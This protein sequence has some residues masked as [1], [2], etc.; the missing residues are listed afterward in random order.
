[1]ITVDSLCLALGWE[2]TH[3]DAAGASWCT[4]SGWRAWR[5]YASE[6][7]ALLALPLERLPLVL[8]GGWDSRLISLYPGLLRLS[9]CLRAL[10]YRSCRYAWSWRTYEFRRS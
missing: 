7:D 9:C 3:A 1:M 4:H 6:L 8:A 5:A 2:Q 10:W